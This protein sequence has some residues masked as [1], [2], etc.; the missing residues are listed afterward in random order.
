MT[1]RIPQILAVV[2]I[3]WA[4]TF[5]AVAQPQEQILEHPEFIKMLELMPQQVTGLQRI[6]REA[7]KLA[8]EFQMLRA[9]AQTDE[10]MRQLAADMRQRTPTLA[11]SQ[12]KIDE[13]LKPEQRKK[14]S[15][16]GF[17]VS[18]GNNSSAQWVALN[19]WTLSFLDLTDTQKEQVR[20]LVEERDAK[21]EVLDELVDLHDPEVQ[22]RYR[23][24]YGEISAGFREQTRTLLTAEQRAK[25]IRLTAEAPAL[26]ERLGLPPLPQPRVAD[27]GLFQ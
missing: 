14:Y 6:W 15:E 2:V 5:N 13:V 17:Q 16:I 1:K 24:I 4:L 21:R 20:K 7:G 19:E 23:T 12:A 9:Q 22:Q 3:A 18:G 10:E 27:T 11:E 25:V 26:R 8:D